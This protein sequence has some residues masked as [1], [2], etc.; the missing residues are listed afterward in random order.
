[1]PRVPVL[2]LAE[3]TSAEDNFWCISID[4]S[5]TSREVAEALVV[6]PYYVVNLAPGLFKPHE[7]VVTEQQWIEANRKL[8]AAVGDERYL[9]LLL[10]VLKGA[11]PVTVHERVLA[12][13][14]TSHEYG[15]GENTRL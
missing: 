15:D 3:S 6:N 10:D 12:D 11:D 14:F 5:V 4:S 2:E 8:L 7:T 9:R 1:M 13:L